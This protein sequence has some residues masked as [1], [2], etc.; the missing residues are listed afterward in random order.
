M[1][2]L[3]AKMMLGDRSRLLMALGGVAFAILL[4]N[5]QVGMLLGFIRKTSQLV[6]YCEADIWVGHR[7]ALNVDFT[8]FIQERWIARVRSV[9][10]VE[11]ADPYLLTTAEAKMRDGRFVA[12]IVVGCDPT[13]QLGNAW[14]MAKGS[15]PE[16]IQQPDSIIVDL[17]EAHKLG[18]CRIG[19]AL[20]LNGQRARIA[21]MTDGIVTFAAVPY[22]F[23]TLERARRYGTGQAPPGACSYFLVK[24]RPGTDVAA[25]AARIQEQVPHLLVLDRSSYSQKTRA[26]WMVETGVGLAF[27]MTALLGILIGLGVVAHTMYATVN[28]RLA[29]YAT[30]KA[31][32]AD[33]R[34][35]A[36]F[37]VAQA[38]SNAVLGS[39]LG[40]LISAVVV[41]AIS[42]PRA[43]VA[44]P[45]WVSALSVAV[46]LLVC[47]GAAA[48]PYL[49]LR[50]LDPASV[51]RR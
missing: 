29:E 33:D 27:G 14:A 3:A 26:F 4:A 36:R 9:D 49:R 24:A 30:L 25:L 17:Q 7:H 38:M 6:D 46:A 18:D 12:V 40:L 45:W 13:S 5:L 22:A 21:G 19:D 28:D 20:E 31:L 35:V 43:T 23:T 10:G 16:D 34:C 8:S 1:W 51:L 37:L 50:R 48:L 15:R 44:M 41:L 11:R 32:G 47:L 39:V 2:L 42:S